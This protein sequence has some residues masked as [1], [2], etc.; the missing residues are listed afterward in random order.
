MKRE[1]P[2]ISLEDAT[3]PL[4]ALSQARGTPSPAATTPP[5]LLSP[6]HS[7]RRWS[8]RPGPRWRAALCLLSALILPLVW[9]S[10]SQDSP[11]GPG[12]CTRHTLGPPSTPPP[13]L[14]RTFRSL[15]SMLP[16]LEAARFLSQGS[17]VCRGKCHHKAPQ[18][19]RPRPPTGRLL[20]GQVGFSCLSA[21][22]G[23]GA[24]PWS[25]L[26]VGSPPRSSRTQD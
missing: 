22:P 26:R 24:V 25:S 6:Q 16:V 12:S 13:L 10:H 21:S 9:P 2:A 15:S 11:P 4:P 8:P 19:G 7:A 17:P 1:I 5:S 14:S 23:A 18:G 20:P 3:S